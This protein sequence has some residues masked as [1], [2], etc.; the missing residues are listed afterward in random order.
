MMIDSDDAAFET[1][2][3][4]DYFEQSIFDLNRHDDN[5]FD[6]DDWV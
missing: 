2:S 1:E 6:P 5:P 3:D 4:R